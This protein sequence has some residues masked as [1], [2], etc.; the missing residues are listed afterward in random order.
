MHFAGTSEYTLGKAKC[1]SLQIYL[2]QNN[3]CLTRRQH[4]SDFLGLETNP[5]DLINM[6]GISLYQFIFLGMSTDLGLSASAPN[7]WITRWQLK[8]VFG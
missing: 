6:G 7:F 5:V 1:G 4:L 8:E 2:Y 3:I